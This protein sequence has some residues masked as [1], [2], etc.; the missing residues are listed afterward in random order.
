MVPLSETEV[1]K[2]RREKADRIHAAAVRFAGEIGM[3]TAHLEGLTMLDRVETGRCVLC[4]GGRTRRP[5]GPR[6]ERTPGQKSEAALRAWATR[7]AN[8][9][10]AV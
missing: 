6:V 5:S 1:S 3:E 7:R 2:E 9:A 10:K 8:A 4:G